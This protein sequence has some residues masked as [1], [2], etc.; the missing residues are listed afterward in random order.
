[1]PMEQMVYLVMVV[2]QQIIPISMELL[3]MIMQQKNI[4]KV[5]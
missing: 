1:M 5:R 2:Q 4:I 3:I